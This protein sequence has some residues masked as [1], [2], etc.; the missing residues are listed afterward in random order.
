[1]DIGLDGRRQPVDFPLFP[2]GSGGNIGTHQVCDRNPG[3][4]PPHFLQR[5]LP[6][7]IARTRDYQYINL[8]E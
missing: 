7:R 4:H 8:L 1:M 6:H 5:R 2:V 3:T